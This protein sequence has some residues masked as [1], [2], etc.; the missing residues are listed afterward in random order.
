VE[1]ESNLV[2]AAGAEQV[3]ARGIVVAGG[4]AEQRVGRDVLD[5]IVFAVVEVEGDAAD[6]AVQ[7][8]ASRGGDDDGKV[9]VAE[10]A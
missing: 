4:I 5:P 8:S 7:I 2:A 10:H 1:V 3:H 9:V 6:L